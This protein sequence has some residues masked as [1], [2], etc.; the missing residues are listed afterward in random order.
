VQLD[1]ARKNLL[2]LSDH[3]PGAIMEIMIDYDDLHVDFDI[4][5]IRPYSAYCSSEVFMRSHMMWGRFLTLVV[6]R[7]Q[8]IV[9]AYA[10]L[11]NIIMIFI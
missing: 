3:I 4:N 11:Y 5:S 2:E 7:K 9:F 10:H 6:G 8:H 1:L